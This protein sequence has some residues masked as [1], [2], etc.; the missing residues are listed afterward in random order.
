MLRNTLI[1]T[2]ALAL[3]TFIG[4][5]LMLNKRLENLDIIPDYDEVYIW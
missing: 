2:A 1:A 5:F 4:G 3:L